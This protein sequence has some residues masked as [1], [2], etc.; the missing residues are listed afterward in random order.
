MCITAGAAGRDVLDTLTALVHHSLV[1]QREQADGEPRFGMLE[2][3]REFALDQ[4]DASGEA[5][6]IGELHALFFLSLARTAAPHLRR[7]GDEP[8]MRGLTRE[9]D[10]LRAA[11]GWVVAH[12]AA[13]TGLLLVATLAGWF[14]REALTE[15]QGWAAAVLMLPGA[16]RP[17]RARAQALVAAGIL[18]VGFGDRETARRWLEESVAIF[19]ELDDPWLLAHALD[20]LGQAMGMVDLD[21]AR[22]LGEEAV[23]RL[24]QAN[25]PWRLALA[26]SGL[27]R[28]LT[29]L[30]DA[31]RARLPG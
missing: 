17:S 25:R 24:R 12:D 31:A 7:A 27:G 14:Y 20:W 10:N 19:R 2:T 30:G 15:G 16:A 6:A 26:L 18:A 13:E 9:R 11:L 4:L 22:R 1:Y 3:I 8:W 5:D 23:A 21:A 29:L 28:T